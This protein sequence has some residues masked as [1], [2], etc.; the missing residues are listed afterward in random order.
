MALSSAT[1]T[2]SVTTGAVGTT[3]TVS[4][5][6]FQPTAIFL[7]W[8]GSAAA[9]QAEGDHKFGTGMAVSTSS[10]RAYTTQSDHANLTMATDSALYNDCCVATLTIA[11]AIDGKADLDLIAADGF[12]LIVD[13]QFA[14]A[15][16]VGWI[17]WGGSDLT[18]AQIVDITQPAAT[19]NQ[20]IATSFALN[21][22]IDDK[23]VI[24][25]G[26]VDS[27]IGTPT[28]FS[29]YCVGVAAGDT[30][31]QAVLTGGSDDAAATSITYSY[32]RA[33]ECIA[34]AYT[35]TVPDRGNLTLWQ[36]T[37]FRINWTN[38]DGASL[39]YSAL[40]MKGGRWQVGDS[41]TS[42]GTTNQVESTTYVPVA[43]L[44]GS[45]NRAASSAGTVSA[46]DE[47]CVG[48]ATS[49][50]S[51]WCAGVLDKDASAAA[52]VGVS[53][54]NTCFY[55]NQSTAA[56]IAIE[57]LADLVSFDATPSF[58]FVMDDADP[59]A[60]FFFYLLAAS[61]PAAGGNKGPLIEG[62]LTR[63]RLIHGRLAA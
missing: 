5:L 15:V 24:F 45:A 30:I 3:F 48:A 44:T 2:I 39:K 32:C 11:G 35:D 57:G 53:F 49:A 43:L 20:D 50:T 22:G 25:I 47:R 10:R 42:T 26:G 8:S 41:L 36:A 59:V 23:A 58:T 13:D 7:S 29:S 61:A 56:T 31:A 14:N 16:V 33:G 52:D 1:G 18:N 55:C 27:A 6:S 54:Q 34:N 46:T 38:V 37:G 9:G 19:G 4:G 21:T 28:T 12:R 62:Q 17:A 63:S 51:R 60:S 40:V